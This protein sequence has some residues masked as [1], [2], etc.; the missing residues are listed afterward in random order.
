L[1]SGEPGRV[2]SFGSGATTNYETL[3]RYVD[4]LRKALL[5]HECSRYDIRG[6]DILSGARK[7][8][9]ND[10]AFREYLTPGFDP[11][12][13][14]RLENCFYLHW[15]AQGYEVQVGTHRAREVD[16]VIEKGGQ[17]MYAQICYLLA[18]D[19]VIEREYGSLEGI[20]DSCPKMVVSLD[21]AVFGSRN[22]IQHRQA[23][24]VLAEP[25]SR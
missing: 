14:R 20:R 15:K 22:G 21:D 19:E 10:L 1:A 7:Y 13:S 11:G 2:I 8:Y 18:D 17:R 23:W 4:H 3:S 24:Q 16:F 25:A 9:L 6:K 12:L 5:I